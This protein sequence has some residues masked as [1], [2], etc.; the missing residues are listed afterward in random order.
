MIIKNK[1]T[2]KEKLEDYD[3]FLAKFEAK[4][5]TDDCYTPRDVYEAVVDHVFALYD[6]PVPPTVGV[7]T[8]T[9]TLTDEDEREV[10]RLSGTRLTD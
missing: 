7:E 10:A 6:L 4:K 1:R 3:A 8:I 9:L 2:L 5:T